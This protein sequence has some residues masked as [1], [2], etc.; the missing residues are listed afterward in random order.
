MKSFQLLVCLALACCC[1]AQINGCNVNISIQQQISGLGRNGSELVN[2]IVHILECS[3]VFED[4]NVFMRR[5][6]Y[7]E[8]MDGAEGQGRTGIW[9]ATKHHLN[10]M[11]YEVKIGSFPDLVNQTCEKFGVDMKTAVRN[12]ES[13][14]LR[15]PLVSGVVARFYLTVERR[16]QIPSAEDVDGQAR[17]WFSQFRIKDGTATP[18]HF[19]SRVAK[20]KGVCQCSETEGACPALPEDWM[21]RDNANGLEVMEE[22][23][24]QL[25]KS[26]IFPPDYGFMRRVAYVETRNGTVTAAVNTPHNLCHK[27][28]G[29]WGITEYVF[30]HMKVEIQGN[31]TKYQKL[32]A[33]SEDICAEFGVNVTGPE[34]LNM[35]NPLVS[36][37]AARFYFYYQVILNNMALPNNELPEDLDG[38]AIFFM[39]SYMK[40]DINKFLKD[41]NELEGCKVNVDIM[42][43][44][45]ISGSLKDKHLDEVFDFM[46][47]FVKNLTIGPRNDRVGAVVFGDYAHVM[48]TMSE[49]SNKQKL[50][51]AIKELEKDAK[52]VRRGETQNTNTSHGLTETLA[53][54]VSDARQSHTVFRVAMV[55]SDGV[56]DDPDS[57]VRE[58]AK[59]RNFSVLVYAIGVGDV[60]DKEM[61][62]IASDRHRY[63]HLDDF[64]SE[65]FEA[66]RNSYF[67][68]ICLNATTDITGLKHFEGDLD[69]HK[70]M[71]Y[72]RLVPDNGLTIRVCSS[73]GR[74]TISV[75]CYVPENSGDI[76]TF[77]PI[78]DHRNDTKET[79]CL[80]LGVYIPGSIVSSEDQQ[81]EEHS[82]RRL[83]RETVTTEVHI[84]VEGMETENVFVMATTD[85]DDPNDCVGMEVASDCVR[86]S[87]S[88]EGRGEENR[89]SGSKGPSKK[90]VVIAATVSSTGFILI[91]CIVIVS[92]VGGWVLYRRRKQQQ[93]KKMEEEEEEYKLLDNEYIEM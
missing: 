12:P 14:D 93:Q 37:I 36:G 86:P 78:C 30:H 51:S 71:R 28:V 16:I 58:A 92:S 85:G 50:L 3:G 18:H 26:H 74:V 1:C 84:T 63:T 53:T 77:K 17:F 80:C 62:A 61:R 60:N 79:S 72:T 24:R 75:F 20:L 45:D 44:L 10:A 70:I 69:L 40:T 21:N 23:L 90:T 67:N 27:A 13:L 2:A 7:V 88:P 64:D 38:Q 11:A 5:L 52:N 89:R 82:R 6:A 22:V 39:K 43:V 15:D 8:T 25:D 35:R 48:F 47:K 91:C 56:S 73:E 9:N 81:Q 83:K 55:L 54:F 49:H 29:M 19:T 68:D 41:V 66:V 59:L 87:E 4:D 33:A 46:T 76:L 57:T 31:I 34:K 32:I 42:F 65:Q